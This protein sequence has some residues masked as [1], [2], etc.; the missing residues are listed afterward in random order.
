MAVILYPNAQSTLTLNG[1]TFQ[2]LAEGEALNLSPANEK[3]ARTNSVS[4]GV[5]I[6]NRS[7]SGV[8]DLTVMVQKHSPDDKLL[9]DARN[10]ALPTLF[11][12]SMK[13]SYSESGTTKK[14]TTSLESGSITS[15]P[16]NV[17]NNQEADNTRTYVIQFRDAKELF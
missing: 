7:D 1:Y 6:S 16:G 5:S 9:N 10:S 8:H 2:H 14:A 12:G 15:Q 13:R 3:T 11:N 4:N 17:D